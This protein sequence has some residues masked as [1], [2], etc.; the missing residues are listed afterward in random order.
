[1]IGTLTVTVLYIAVNAA[2]LAVLPLETV[3]GST[4]VAADFADAL[5]GEGGASVMAAVVMLSTLGA[6]TGVILA[7]PRVYLSM[8]RDGLLFRRAGAVHPRFRTPHHAILLQGVWASVLVATG[9]YR[10]LFTRVV[11]TEWIFFGLMAASLVVLRRRS[12][13][14]PAYRVRG[15]PVLPAIFV[16][17]TIAIVVNQ[18]IS[19]PLESATGLLIVLAGVPVYFIWAGGRRQERASHAGD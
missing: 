6:I 9:S 7:G 4:R 1:M 8:A 16:A 17:S 14:A 2:Y 13:Y 10:A 3:V 19:D 11:Y 12:G 15:H 18:I 5:L